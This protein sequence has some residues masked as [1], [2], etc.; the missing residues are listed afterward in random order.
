MNMI[1]KRTSIHFSAI[2]AIVLSI[3]S[4]SE[5]EPDLYDAPD[6]IYF[7]NRTSGNLLTDS[8]SVTFVYEQDETMTLDISV[9]VQSIGRQ[10]DYDR[11]VELRV[12]SDNAEEGVDY[13]LPT[14]AVLPA[15]T[16]SFNYIVRLKRTEAIKTEAKSIYLELSSNEYFSTFLVRDSTG[17]SEKPYTE[18]L[19]YRIDFT[20]FYS[21]APAGWREEY[22]GVFSERKLRLLWKLFDN[23]VDRAAYNV[24]GGI[25]FNKWVYM[26]QEVDKYILTQENILLGYEQGEVDPDALEDP[27]AEGDDRRL[28]DFT[29]VIS[30]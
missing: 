11:P 6:G 17:N 4:C 24:S 21:T 12:W 5:Q 9:A 19:K 23:V 14:P 26:K 7:N 29:P 10:A 8:V 16:S 1:M 25:P 28:L 13:E 3:C 20:D 22:V 18:M 15:N 2:L 30:D 27:T